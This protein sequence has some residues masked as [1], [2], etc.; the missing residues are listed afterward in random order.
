MPLCPEALHYLEEIVGE[1]PPRQNAFRVLGLS[2]FDD[3]RAV[4]RREQMLSMRRFKASGNLWEGPLPQR[5]PATARQIAQAVHRLRSPA[6]RLVDELFWFWPDQALPSLG[7]HPEQVLRHWIDQEATSSAWQASHNLAVFYLTKAIDYE[8]QEMATGHPLTDKQRA[9]CVASW[10]RAIPRWL[11]LRQRNE[12]WQQYQCRVE[13]FNDPRFPESAIVAVRRTLEEILLRGVIALLIR[14]ARSNRNDQFDRCLHL[15]K[16]TGFGDSLLLSVGRK[17]LAPLADEMR[18]LVESAEQ[19]VGQS[20][21]SGTQ[22]VKELVEKTR[23]MVMLFDTILPESDMMTCTAC[24][25]LCVALLGFQVR[26]TNVTKDW[27]DAIASLL[28]IQPLARSQKIQDRLKE[29]ITIA[30][31]NAGI[32]VV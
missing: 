9:A 12:M 27:G 32:D 24:D 14:A 23:T 10:K 15:L 21:Q 4:R 20:P 11:Q 30:K 19:A 13:H 3:M 16:H 28:T 17:L 31:G 1:D 18:L 25:D 2:V 6:C 8:S 5:E 26:C 22:Y 29:N 7:Q